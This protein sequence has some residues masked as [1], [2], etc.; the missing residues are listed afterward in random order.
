[1]SELLRLQ[2]TKQESST[3]ACVPLRFW[4][5]VD[6]LRALVDVHPLVC[7]ITVC[8]W[9]LPFTFDSLTSQKACSVLS[10]WWT[11]YIGNEYH[12]WC[13]EMSVVH[14]FAVTFALWSVSSSFHNPLD[15]HRTLCAVTHSLHLL[16][17]CYDLFQWF[18]KRTRVVI[19]SDSTLATLKRSGLLATGIGRC[20]TIMDFNTLIDTRTNAYGFFRIPR[21]G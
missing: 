3:V 1:M 6:W 7:C 21:T 17:D 12:G 9:A 8:S 10:L 16:I 2:A 18:V 19:R 4:V 5:L 20:Q 15:S 11:Y 14:F 13:G